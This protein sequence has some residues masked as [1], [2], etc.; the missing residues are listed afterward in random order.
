M[1]YDTTPGANSMAN[2]YLEQS[3]GRYTV[4]GEPT[5]WVLFQAIRAIY[6]DDVESPLGG[7]AVWYFLNDTVDGWY[8]STDR[9]RQ[10]PC[11]RSMRTWN[12]STSG[13]ATTADGDGNFDEPDGY[14]DTFQ[15]VHAGEGEEAGAPVDAIWSHSWY[16]YY[17]A[18]GPDG[19]GPDYNGWGGVR[20]GDSDYLG[21][22]VHHP[23]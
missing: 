12:D 1:L 22:Q 15:S 21:W 17:S 11:S 8:A 5:D 14:I 23:A 16:A 6:N 2:F 3:S 19:T 20:V 13:I 7:N 9:S 18:K 10:D 4:A